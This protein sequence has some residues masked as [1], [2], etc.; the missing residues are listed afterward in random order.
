MKLKRIALTILAS[1]L[2]S[3]ALPRGGAFIVEATVQK[4]IGDEVAKQNTTIY[5]MITNLREE[6][7]STSDL[8][9]KILESIL[10]QEKRIDRELY[11]LKKKVEE[12]ASSLAAL[13]D[14]VKK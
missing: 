5:K 8:L 10:D 13:T 12:I 6:F 11:G 4:T 3:C 2:L 9:R 7:R 1:S 14:K